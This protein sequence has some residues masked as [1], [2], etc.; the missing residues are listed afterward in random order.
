ME[1]SMTDTYRVLT[2]EDD[3]DPTTY[4]RLALIRTTWHTEHPVR[5]P[6]SVRA[7]LRAVT[8]NQRRHQRPGGR[9]H[10]RTCTAGHVASGRTPAIV[11][12]LTPARTMSK[13]PTPL[14]I[15][16]Q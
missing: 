12:V 4:L 9:R 13:A 14:M 2:V 7:V 16:Y 10:V 11:E 8:S 5:C 15:S 1:G 3:P 6:A